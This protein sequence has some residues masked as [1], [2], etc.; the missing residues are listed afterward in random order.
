MRGFRSLLGTIAAAGIFAG[1]S[2]RAAAAECGLKRIFSV[3][4]IVAPNGLMLVPAKIINT[5]LL[6]LLDTGGQMTG[7]TLPTARR[8]GLDLKR[9]RNGLTMLGG[10]SDALTII[11]SMTLGGIESKDVQVMILP[12]SPIDRDNRVVGTL[13]PNPKLDLEVDYADRKLSVFSSEH[14][15]GGVVYWPAQ[16]IAVVPM[17]LDGAHATVP[18]SIEGHTLKAL[19]D[20]GTTDTTMNLAI[21]HLWFDLD[22]NGPDVEKVGQVGNTRYGSIYRHRFKN[23][24][25]EGV[26]ITNP[27]II[28]MPNQN[29]VLPDLILGADILTKMHLYFSYEERKVY[30]TAAKPPPAASSPPVQ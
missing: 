9:S 29:R 10:T 17:G 5:N 25:F 18:V 13:V 21:A 22:Y 2:E 4:T 8:F 14:C 1:M 16:V 24:S 27:S 23:I 26:S 12:P 11:P 20:S 7:I 19:I 6:L 15:K 28:L 30:I 3:N